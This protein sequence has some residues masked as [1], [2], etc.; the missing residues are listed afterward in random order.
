MS[1]VLSPVGFLGGGSTRPIPTYYTTDPP[2]CGVHGGDTGA[3]SDNAAASSRNVST[4]AMGR[5]PR[6]PHCVWISGM[7][8]QALNKAPCGGKKVKPA[9]LMFGDWLIQS[10]QR[11]SDPN[12]PSVADLCP[13]HRTT[14]ISHRES[15]KCASLGFWRMGCARVQRG[16]GQLPVCPLRA[17]ERAGLTS[18]TFPPPPLQ[19]RRA[20]ATPV[21]FE[22]TG[23]QRH[24]DAKSVEI[25]DSESGP[26]ASVSAVSDDTQRDSR[27]TSEN[28]AVSAPVK[29]T[30]AESEKN[31]AMPR[32]AAHAAS[33]TF[34]RAPA[35]TPVRQKGYHFDDDR[36]GG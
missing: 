12:F 34:T 29:R 20:S 27:R 18:C 21:G 14:Y 7:P 26:P 35:Q 3:D 16:G 4:H 10:G 36:C 11:V 19:N 13:H 25:Q 17:E 32:A 24:P 30:G 23:N 5:F 6:H 9:T 33:P 8:A 31:P 15:N 1:P 28:S 2:S 22:P